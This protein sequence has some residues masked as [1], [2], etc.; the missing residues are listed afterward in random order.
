MVVD[1]N[2]SLMSTY[3]HQ[4]GSFVV[5]HLLQVVPV[6]TPQT[7]TYSTEQTNR[8]SGVTRPTE[9]VME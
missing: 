3:F 2:I 5:E 6:P 8:G 4:Q 7:P 1:G 9:S